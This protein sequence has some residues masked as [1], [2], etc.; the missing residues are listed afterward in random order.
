M[1]NNCNL[2][3]NGNNSY[4]NK[5]EKKS[6]DPENYITSGSDE[7][8]LPSLSF[9]CNKNKYF[10]QTGECSTK[11][12]NNQLETEL[13]A[14]DSAHFIMNISNNYLLSRL[15][16][17]SADI[18]MPNLITAK[19]SNVQTQPKQPTVFARNT[20]IN[21]TLK[22]TKT[23]I[24]YKQTAKN[25]LNDKKKN[26]EQKGVSNQAHSTIERDKEPCT[27]D[28][29]KEKDKN[30]T[31]N[32]NTTN[33]QTSNP[34]N[35]TKETAHRSNLSQSNIASTTSNSNNPNI[36]T[37]IESPHQTEKKTILPKI[38]I[39][40]QYDDIINVL[41]QVNTTK[42]D[43]A[44]KLGE[45][46]K[47]NK[48]EFRSIDIGTDYVCGQLDVETICYFPRQFEAL[49]IAYCASY[50]NFILSVA[51]SF[52]WD[53]VTGGKSNSKFYKC[54][55]NRFILKSVNKK[56]FKMFIESAPQYF[57]HNAKYLFHKMPSA[58]A[59]ILGA[60]RINKKRNQ[61]G[62]NEKFYIF[63]MENMLYTKDPKQ[64]SA[65]GDMMANTNNSNKGSSIE[66]NRNLTKRA[67]AS[68]QVTSTLGSNIKNNFENMEG[69]KLSAHQISPEKD[70]N[71]TKKRPKLKT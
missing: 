24:E 41:D 11:I 34:L 12:I 44:K 36:Q 40:K 14:D 45:A 71:K 26:T 63:L 61:D 29:E 25:E 51:Y 48:L 7:W 20:E 42:K 66:I 67:S 58:L 9:D 64:I 59:K 70:K 47:S 21:E 43:L 35:Q 32:S 4:F 1:Y 27:K 55:D 65:S 33:I 30:S 37:P 16:T 10:L 31:S 8:Y 56:E 69:K 15:K 19:K 68:Q 6:S 22:N 57:H 53:S 54:H 52:E 18:E 13:L 3:P 5:P 23:N 28:K 17:W 39:A 38:D 49:R 50:E 62:G 2:N 46:V 60:Y